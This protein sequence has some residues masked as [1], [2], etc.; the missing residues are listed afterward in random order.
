MDDFGADWIAVPGGAIDTVTADVDAWREAGGTHI[1]LLTMGLG[2]DSAE[3]HIEYLTS[4]ADALSL[5]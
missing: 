5:S 1:S 4:V 3:A 2:F